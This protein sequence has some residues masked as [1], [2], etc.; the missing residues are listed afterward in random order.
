MDNSVVIGGLGMVGNATGHTFGIKDYYDRKGSNITLVEIALQKRYVF[1]ALPT[2][3]KEGTQEGVGEMEGLIKQILGYGGGQKIFIIRSTILP[4]TTKRLMRNCDTTAIV[5]NPEFLTE[6]TWKKDA[7]HPDIIVLGGEDH[8]FL[9]D[10]E[11][12]YKGRFKGSVDVFKTDSIT[13]ELA[14]YA[15][16]SFYVTK[17]VFANEIFDTCKN[18]GA[19]YEMI[20]EIMYARK[21]IGKNHLRIF[22]EDKKRGADGACLAKDIEAFTSCTKSKLIELVN[23]LNKN[24]CG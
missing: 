3:T 9:D 17:V 8:V 10:V 1:M 22:D 13:S 11:A 15:I 19:N 7:E 5:H 18:M 6:A 20:K 23:K 14:K 2:P 24:L 4:G 12:L 21:W 16:N